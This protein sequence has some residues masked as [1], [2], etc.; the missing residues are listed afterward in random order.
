M[1]DY[2]GGA[3]FL[4]L[5]IVSALLE[6]KTSGRGQVVDAAMI[7]GAANLI[8]GFH[9]MR[10]VGRLSEERGTN[11]LD[12]GA[13]YYNVYETADGK[14]VTLGAIEPA[15]YQQMRDRLG[16]DDPFWDNQDDRSRWPERQVALQRIFSTKTREAW[17]DVF[18]GSDACFAPVLEL[19]ELAEHPH[20]VAR[21]GYV[22]RDGVLHPTPAPRF[23]RTT[24]SLGA[25]APAVGEH[26]D[27]LLAELGFNGDEIENLRSA[28]VVA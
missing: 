26:T 7:D 24:S 10:A 9:H 22:V 11:Q 21:E 12:S 15:F 16:L 18:A 5:G 14:W 23:S 4:A 20:H 25:P 2:G 19:S 1:G 28:H 27:T 8:A 3:L 17:C 13:P 6:V